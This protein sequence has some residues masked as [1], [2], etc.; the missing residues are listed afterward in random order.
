MD[1]SL[2]P[3]SCQINFQPLLPRSAVVNPARTT[4]FLND[5]IWRCGELLATPLSLVWPCT[6]AAVSAT[7]PSG[8]LLVRFGT[9]KGQYAMGLLRAVTLPQ[10]SAPNTSDVMQLSSRNF[11]EQTGKFQFSPDKVCADSSSSNAVMCWSLHPSP[12]ADFLSPDRCVLTP[13]VPMLWCAEVST[14]VLLL[15]SSLLTG[16]CWLL[17]FQCCDVLKSPPKSSCW[18]PLSWQVCADSSSSNAVMC[19]SLHPSP[20][21]DVLSWQVCAD[22]SSSNAVMCWS[23]HPSPPAD[24]LSP[25]RCVLTPQVPMLSCAEVSTQVLLLTSSLLTGV[26]WLLKFKCCDV[27]K[28]PPKSSCWR[29]LSWQVCWWLNWQVPI[30]SWQGVCWLL[31]FQCCDVLKSPPKSSCWRPLSWQ[32]CADSSSSNA[33]MCWSLHPS[34]P[35]DVLSPDRCVLTPQVPMLWCAEVST[36]VL[37]LTSSLLTGVCWLL[38][39]QCCDVLKS[40]P[41]SSCWRPLSWQVCADSSSSNAVMCWSLHPSPP[42]DVLSPDRCVLTPQVPMLWC[43]EV[44]TQVLLLTSSLLTGVCWLLKFQCCDVLKSPPKSSCWRPLS[45][46]VCADSSS[47][48]AVMCWSLH[49][50]PPADVLSPDR[51]VLTPQVPMLWCAEVS[52]QVLL[53]TSSLL[54]GVCWLLKFQCCDVLKSPPKSSCWRPL[55][56]QVCA[57]S[58][59]SNAVMCWSLHPSPPADVLSPDRC[60]LTPQVPMLWCAEVSTQVLLLT[61]SLLTGVCWLLKF[62]CCDVLKSPPKS[63]CWRPLSWQ[64]CADSSSSNAVMCWSLHPSPP[65]DVLSPDRCADD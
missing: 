43:A 8:A 51:C 53:L 32:V 42:A 21:A 37:L 1:L 17:K 63:S 50:S 46:Q 60:V 49:P 7:S 18:R 12:P 40:P 29:P 30:L 65:A 33:V 19:W 23:L 22:S 31:K 34:P 26:R 45:W 2:A 10:P 64:V 5:H 35:A 24:V 41:K 44:S 58:S 57:D 62:Q 39:F 59:S 11:V 54:T 36:Q 25:D 61:S 47:S 38:K 13:Q 52:T 48:N 4:P 15:T 9:M 55:S 28:S 6:C 14:Q 16:V 56:W 27:L 20:P 3:P